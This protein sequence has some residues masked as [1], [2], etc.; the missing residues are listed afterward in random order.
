MQGSEQSAKNTNMKVWGSRLQFK[1]L[2]EMFSCGYKPWYVPLALSAC[3]C[4][5]CCWFFTSSCPCPGINCVPK[6][7]PLAM[8][9]NAIVPIPAFSCFCCHTWMLD[10]CV[11][12]EGSWT[13]KSLA[14]YTLTVCAP[15]L[16]LPCVSG[17]IG[18]LW[19]PPTPHWSLF[20][21]PR[22]MGSSYL[23]AWASLGALPG[24][25]PYLKIT[26]LSS[27]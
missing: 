15:D 17:S 11:S 12:G 21:C 19:G 8:V 13:K 23:T 25:S 7:S 10:L 20:P 1:V 14:R 6:Q 22:H 2:D 26:S 9:S 24:L 27:A 16:H 5:P 4:C 18:N 3:C